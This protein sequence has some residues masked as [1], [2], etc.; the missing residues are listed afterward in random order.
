MDGFFEKAEYPFKKTK[1]DEVRGG[2]SGLLLGTKGRYKFAVDIKYDYIDGTTK[3][4]LYSL[5]YTRNIDVT[6]K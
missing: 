4:Y 5:T 2:D 1:M 3:Y 6:Y